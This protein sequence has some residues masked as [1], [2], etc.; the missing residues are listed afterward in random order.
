LTGT[1]LAGSIIRG[2]YVGGSV[3]DGSNNGGIVGDMRNSMMI[4]CFGHVYV[5]GDD[6]QGGLA[7]ILDGDNAVFNCYSAGE[8]RGNRNVGGIAGYA[9]NGGS[10]TNCYSMSI[11]SGNTHAGGIA[12]RLNHPGFP[13]NNNVAVNRQITADAA[14]GRIYGAFDK[15]KKPAAADNYALDALPV[16]GTA[17][18]GSAGD[19]NGE[20]RNEASLRR[21]AFR[22]TSA[23]WP[24]SAWD[25]DTVASPSKTWIIWKGKSFPYLQE[26]SAP[27]A[28]V[29]VQPDG[30]IGC[31]LRSGAAKVTVA[32]ESGKALKTATSLSAGAN[33]FNIAGLRNNTCITLTVSETGKMPSYPVSFIYITTK[34]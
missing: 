29:A 5:A 14:V 25:M 34:K 19:R 22:N 10:L 28:S 31:E 30:N 18:S 11:I 24:G 15:G 9:R 33:T 6:T 20:S 17:V 3:S 26:Q 23:C 13:L 32:N 8:V 12:G 1:A 16:N 21:P 2:C 27:V 7:G 4:G